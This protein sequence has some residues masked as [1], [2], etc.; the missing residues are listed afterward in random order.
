MV[1]EGRSFIPRNAFNTSPESRSIVSQEMDCF[2]KSLQIEPIQMNHLNPK[3][4]M[5]IIYPLLLTSILTG[6][7]FLFSLTSYIKPLDLPS[8]IG[9]FGIIVFYSYF[10]GF[11]YKSFLRKTNDSSYLSYVYACMYSIIYLPI[12]LSLSVLLGMIGSILMFAMVLLTQYSVSNTL[13][14]GHS[15]ESQKRQFIFSLMVLVIQF[16]FLL[17]IEALVSNSIK[18]MPI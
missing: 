9:V 5:T 16:V 11:A 2:V 3:F 1:T 17:G 18:K 13:T 8:F 12:A 6:F 15:F 7:L 10:A 14:L 4:I